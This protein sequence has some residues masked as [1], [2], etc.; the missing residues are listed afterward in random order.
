MPPQAADLTQRFALDTQGFE[1]LKHSA[2]NGADAPTAARTCAGMSS[3]PSSVCVYIA[4]PSGTSRS[5]NASR[6]RRTAGSA[7]S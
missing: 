3:S 4:S 7:F 5:R 1:A 6:S 2:R